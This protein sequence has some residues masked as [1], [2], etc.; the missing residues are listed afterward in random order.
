[1]MFI[2]LFLLIGETNTQCLERNEDKR[3]LYNLTSVGPERLWIQNLLLSDTETESEISD[4]DSH[5]REMLKNHLSERKYRGKYYSTL[6]V[7]LT[8]PIMQLCFFSMTPQ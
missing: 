7:R 2:L 6:N 4:E 8:V 1:M 3:Y 5:I